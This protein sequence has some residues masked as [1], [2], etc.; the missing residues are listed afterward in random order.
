[1]PENYAKI[2]RRR[3]AELRMELKRQMAQG[4][5]LAQE[6]QKMARPKGRAGSEAQKMAATAESSSDEETRAHSSSGEEQTRAAAS[7]SEEEAREVLATGGDEHYASCDE[8]H[9]EDHD[10]YESCEED[11]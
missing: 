10:S 9:D 7:S 2:V 5:M 6:I 4:L 11:A 3:N 1:M 8:Y